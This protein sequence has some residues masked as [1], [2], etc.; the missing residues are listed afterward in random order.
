MKSYS[1]EISLF[2]QTN[3]ED[4]V[5]FIRDK[6]KSPL[7]AERHLVGLYIEISS[8]RTYAESILVSTKERVLRYG[9]NARAIKYK[10]MSIIYTVHN[11]RAIVHELLPSSM[12]ISG[13]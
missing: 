2:A 7:T 3:I 13:L 5:H 1:I 4:Y 12:I 9:P 10:K 8:L 6:Y 11:N